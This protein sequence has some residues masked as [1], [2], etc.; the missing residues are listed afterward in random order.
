MKESLFSELE[1]GDIFVFKY[2]IDM[3]VKEENRYLRLSQVLPVVYKFQKSS[4]NGYKAYTILL[5]NTNKDKKTNRKIK[6]YTHSE[7]SVYKV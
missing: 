2:E 3:M 4:E 1:I 6:G 5:N 7:T